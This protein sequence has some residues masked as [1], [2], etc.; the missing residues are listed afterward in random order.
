METKIIRVGNSRGV[1]LPRELLELYGFVEGDVV[2]FEE[3]REGI[4]LRRAAAS[5]E[6]ISY[7][8]AYR[9]MAQEAAERQEWGEWDETAG[10][11]LDD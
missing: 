1:R 3:R 5:E 4:L 9:E 7:G 10:D 11:G 8:E 2:T 6:H